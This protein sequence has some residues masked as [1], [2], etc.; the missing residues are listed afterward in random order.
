MKTAILLMN[1]GGPDSVSAIK[2]FLF[3]L[4]NDKNIIGIPQ[5]F[6]YLLAKFISIRRFSTAKEIYGYLGGK[7]PILEETER[8][9]IALEKALGDNYKTFI[10]MRYWHPFMEETL[11][12]IDEYAPDKVILL[13]LYPQYS[14]T[15]TLSS[16]HTCID[17]IKIEG[18]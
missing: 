18:P 1:L 17:T 13:P 9:G 15:T 4:F 16:F 2:P 7:S 6:R 5:P 11:H 3:N 8:Q 10:A 14:T 12:A